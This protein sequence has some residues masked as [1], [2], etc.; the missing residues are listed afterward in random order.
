MSPSG[1]LKCD[2]H[3]V[4]FITALLHKTFYI[5]GLNLFGKVAS[6]RLTLMGFLIG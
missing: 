2:S 4:E 1:K 6:G 3:F 5:K